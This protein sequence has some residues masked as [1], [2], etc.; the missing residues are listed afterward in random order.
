M[1]QVLRERAIGTL[2]AGMSTRAVARELNVN[3][4][5]ISHLQCHIREFGSMSNRPDNR[6]PSACQHVGEWFA[7]VNIVNR[8]L[9]G[10]GGVMVLADISY[11]KRTQLHFLDGNLNAQK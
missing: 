1:C 2:T 5:T 4:S 7:D 10:G 11:G 8:V 6:R 3:F 9:H